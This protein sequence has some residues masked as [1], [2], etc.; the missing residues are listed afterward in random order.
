VLELSAATVDDA[1]IWAG[2]IR[3]LQVALQEEDSKAALLKSLVAAA[4]MQGPAVAT[5]AAPAGTPLVSTVVASGTASGGGGEGGMDRKDSTR[6]MG[7]KDKKEKKKGEKEAGKAAALIQRLM[8]GRLARK[9]VRGWVRVVDK[10]DGD[11]YWYNTEKKTSSW[12]PPGRTETGAI[13]T[14]YA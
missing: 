4:A 9:V 8:R 11:V 5:P 14:S 6:D 13:K 12:F 2:A 1:A 7:K 10:A 3:A